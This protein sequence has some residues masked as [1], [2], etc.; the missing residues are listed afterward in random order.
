MTLPHALEAGL[1]DQISD[2]G[3]TVVAFALLRQ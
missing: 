3:E 1:L 2:P